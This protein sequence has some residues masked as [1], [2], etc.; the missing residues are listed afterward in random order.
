MIYI[1][2]RLRNAGQ[3]LSNCAFNLSQDRKEN[4]ID[5]HTRGLLKGLQREWDL[6]LAEIR[7]KNKK[8]KTPG[9]RIRR[10]FKKV[11]AKMV[12]KGF[13]ITQ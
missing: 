6:A 1:P 13:K 7:E 9:N 8:S 12:G 4:T 2:K 11:G 3:L 10:T 5:E